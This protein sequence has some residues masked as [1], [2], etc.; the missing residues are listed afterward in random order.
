MMAVVYILGVVILTRATIIPLQAAAMASV[1][2]QDVQSP[3]HAIT[4]QMQYASM[5]WYVLVSP[6]HLVMMA[7]R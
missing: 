6:D 7:I 2:S 4:I 1:S 3:L 5:N